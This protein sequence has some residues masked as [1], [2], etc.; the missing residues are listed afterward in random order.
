MVLLAAASGCGYRLAARKGDVGA[1]RTIA[2]PTFT[3][4]TTSYRIEQGISEALRRELAR[5]THF[6]VTSVDSGDLVVNG[7][8]T[9]YGIS[10]TVFDDTGRASQYAVNVTLRV[11]ISEPSTGKT[12]LQNDSM[13]FFDTF[14]LSR[15][16]N[17][18]VPEDPAAL[19]R[20][21]ERFAAA[22]VAALVHR[23]S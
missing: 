3:N 22:I 15:N 23:P 14:Q 8:V 7:E 13:N 11:R 16:S 4:S 9:S 2:V 20:L 17:E 1:G 19:K 6:K 21:A 10:P 5:T 18:F 12:L